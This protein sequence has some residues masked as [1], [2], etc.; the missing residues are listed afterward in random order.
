[1]RSSNLKTSL[2]NVLI[3]F[4]V[5]CGANQSTRAD[6]V[7]GEPENLGPTVNS[8]HLDGISDI[9]SDG[10]ELYFESD[11]PGTQGD[12]DIWVTRR[13]TVDDSWEPA[14]NLGTPVNGPQRDYGPCLTRDGLALYFSSTRPGG[15]GGAD[16]YVAAR[17]TIE[18][19]WEDPMNLGAIVN[20]SAWDHCPSVS[21]DGLTLVF[22]SNREKTG[23]A[24]SGLCYIYMSTRLTID[25]PWSTP[26][27][28]GP[29]V[30]PGLAYDS[31]YPSI[32]A[33]GLSL[34]FL[35]KIGEARGLWVATRTSISEPWARVVD[36]G[37]RGAS[38]RFSADGS[39]MYWTS[40][41]FG[42][43]GDADLLQ[44]SV[45]P[46]VDFDADGAIDCLDICDLVEHWGTDNSLYDIG[47]TP[48]GDGVVDVQ[49]LIVLAEHMATDVND[50]TGI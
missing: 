19:Q 8:A 28:L 35:R 50:A 41:G 10:L 12:T 4:V 34:Y 5:L 37:M 2:M 33:D 9:S 31:D 14:V 1:V 36:L 27:R 49:D 40:R 30:N 20:G 32:S 26:V 23:T 44:V 7:F 48:F 39:M 22:G 42:G 16:I 24:H 25:A 45:A 15:S 6:F 3:L 29:E 17:A 46:I 47:P 11:R 43:Y 21:A 18:D 38:P 13:Q